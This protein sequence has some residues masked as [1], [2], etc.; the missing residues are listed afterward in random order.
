MQ[1]NLNVV[2]WLNSSWLNSSIWPIGG[3]L[4]GIISLDQSGPESNGNEG[5]L[6][7]PQSSRTGVSPSDSFVLYPEHSLSN[8]SYPSAEMQSVYFTVSAD[9]AVNNVS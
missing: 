8:R 3:T 5:V 4:S 6:H 7:I 2:K 1:T 9:W